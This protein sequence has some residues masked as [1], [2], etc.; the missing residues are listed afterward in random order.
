[1]SAMKVLGISPKNAKNIAAVFRNTASVAGLIAGIAIES[2]LPI[3]TKHPSR[4]R[5]AKALTVI[6]VK[7]LIH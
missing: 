7:K 4:F 6:P 5:K 2:G 1:M 3:V